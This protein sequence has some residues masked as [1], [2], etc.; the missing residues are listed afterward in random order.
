MIFWELKMEKYE[1]TVENSCNDR[2]DKY[3][4][5]KLPNISRSYI[6]TL[7]EKE[8]VSCNFKGVKP[9]YKVSLGDVISISF[10]YP[11]EISAVPVNI[12]IDILFEDEDILVVNKPKNMPVHPG[13]GHIDDTLVN[14][15]LYSHGDRLSGINGMLRPGIVHRIDMDT[16][17]CLIVCKNDF[18]HKAIAEQIAVHSFKRQ[19]EGVVIGRL[20]EDS[21]KIDKPIARDSKNRLRMCISSEG[22]RAVTHVEVIR[23]YPE[24][25]HVRFTLE[26]GRTHQ[27]RVHMKSIGYPLLGDEVYG[28]SKKWKNLKGQTLHAKNIGFIHPRSREYMEI[29]APLPEYFTEILDKLE[30]SVPP[31]HC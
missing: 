28:N 31:C 7:I 18:S 21:F 19:Y 3:I 14:A 23:A 5:E 30:L 4:S 13:N 26:T 27:I 10:E 20:E 15:L 16:T 6:K 25:T 17:G 9:G 24:Y 11:K 12:P 2:I 8:N 29:E 1:F 22:K